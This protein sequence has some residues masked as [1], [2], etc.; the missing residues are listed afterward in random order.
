MRCIFKQGI[1]C[2]TW[3]INIDKLQ[4]RCT[5]I[6]SMVKIKLPQSG[7]G[8]RKLWAAWQQVA[9]I[10]SLLC[11]FLCQGLKESILKNYVTLFVCLVKSDKRLKV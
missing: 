1:G 6:I 2:Y 3:L 7:I 8:C 10:L 4:E 5:A 9:L 11:F